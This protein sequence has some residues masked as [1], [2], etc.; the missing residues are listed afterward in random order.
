MK[1]DFNR[2]FK[3]LRGDDVPEQ[4]DEVKKDKDGK[5]VVIKKH[6]PFTLKTACV[7]VLLT[8]EL[9]KL[10]CSQCRA[11]LVAPKELTGEEKVRRG[12]LATEIYKGGLVDVGTKDIELLKG[13]IAKEYPS[14]T[15]MQAWAVLDPH[16]AEENK[17]K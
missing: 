3:N 9:G 1:I 14:L 7:T 17:K 15:V 5:E 12:L 2:R 16:E 8:P 10:T 6:P 4:P 11:V 13:L